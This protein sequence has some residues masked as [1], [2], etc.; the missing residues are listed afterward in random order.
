[1]A[2]EK[3]DLRADTVAKIRERIAATT[4][5]RE[6]SR[7]KVASGDWRG[8]EPDPTRITAYTTRIDRKAGHAEAVRG[9]KDFQPAAF[10]ADGAKARRAV[11]RTVLESIE[12]S[13]TATGFMISDRLFLTNQH[14]VKDAKDAALTQIVFD[15]E[16]GED[17]DDLPTTTFA[18]DPDTLFLASD[19]A[20]LDYA[21]IA[22][23][24][25]V[26]GSGTLVDFGN[27][28]LSRTPDRHQLGINANIIQHPEGQ[29]KYVVVR[30]NLIV[31]RN[32][33]ESRLFYETDT[34][35]G[36]SGSP[37]FNDLWD[38]IA[39]HHYGEAAQE[40]SLGDGTKTRSVNE[41]IRISSIYDDLSGK[42]GGLDAEAR[43]LLQE[44]LVLWKDEQ[45]EEKQLT[46]MPHRPDDVATS[47][48]HVTVSETPVA[49][50]A[51]GKALISKEV[52]SMSAPASEAT[53]VVPLEITIRVGAAQGAAAVVASPAPAPASPTLTTQPARTLK[54][55][56]EAKRIDR[57]YSNRNGFD[58]AFVPGLDIDLGKITEP[59][60][61]DI[62]P[63]LAPS[64]R[65]LAGELIYQN[66]SVLMNSQHRIA[67]VTATN[68]DGET[69]IAIDRDTNQPAAQQ[70]AREGDTW[71]KDTR[72]NEALTLTNDFY[73][74]W[75]DYFD[76]GHLTR[77]NDPTWGPN[78]TRAN[79]DTFHFTN[80]SPQHW[81]FNESIEFWQ[82]VERYVL[83]QGLW[84]TGLKKKLTVLQG[85][86]YDAPQPLFADDVEVPNAFWKIVV[87]SG[88]G[89]LKAVALIVDQTKLLPIRRKRLARPDDDTPVK[90]D[91]FRATIAD[92]ARRSKLDFSA[93][94]PFDTAAGELPDVGEAREILT[95]FE[96]LKIK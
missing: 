80:C 45:P 68:I 73:S 70:P 27:C 7:E 6:H 50:T 94:L 83:E 29:R 40:I 84:K 22:V 66:F 12:E 46:T 79:I 67:M 89:G 81:K 26:S 19:E 38:V 9:T 78:A 16:L 76:R 4:T 23:G 37:V 33:S 51:S 52:S 10:L 90:V 25:R 21:L 42:V 72:I 65:P 60:K 43:E 41:G 8:A 13:R 61:G 92:V 39:L 15:Y 3:A 11:A 69:Y 86:L 54:T 31:A 53:I 58:P 56:A 14:V 55:L 62:A 63:L 87:W 88:R 85:P 28:P 48:A 57:D 91:E 18:L 96:Q 93:L 47:E 17:G 44:A 74:E 2:S 59:L 30:N 64:G 20:E 32:D 75:S 82:G 77:R 71:Y 1:M 34:L 35:E 5:E 49:Q 24:K 36:S 95:S